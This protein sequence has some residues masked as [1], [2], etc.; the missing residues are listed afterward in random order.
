MSPLRQICLKSFWANSSNATIFTHVS[1]SHD[2]VQNLFL[3]GLSPFL[4]SLSSMYSQ[5]ERKGAYTYAIGP[6]RQAVVVMVEDG[7]PAS[8]R[9]TA[10]VTTVL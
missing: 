9:Q 5:Q 7:S 3:M 10:T 4:A 6:P 1:Y 8:C 2:A